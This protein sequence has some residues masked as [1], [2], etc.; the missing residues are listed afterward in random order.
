V[1]IKD[2]E[3]QIAEVDGAIPEEVNAH[4]ENPRSP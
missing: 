4:T 3:S 1:L 2:E